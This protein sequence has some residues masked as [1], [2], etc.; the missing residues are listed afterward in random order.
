VLIL[1]FI[2]FLF[3]NQKRLKGIQGQKE[4][5]LKASLIKI[6]TQNKIQEQQLRISRDLYKSIDTQLDYIISSINSLKCSFEINDHKLTQEI[7]IIGGFTFSAK[8]DLKATILEMN[9]I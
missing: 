1:G 6:E 9:K 4:N 5:E 7:E 3:Y 2:G 8:N